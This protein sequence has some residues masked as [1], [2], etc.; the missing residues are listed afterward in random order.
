MKRIAMLLLLTAGIT[1]GAF[2]QTTGTLTLQGTVPGILSITVTPAGA[3]SNLDLTTDV[4]NLTVATV[5][6]RS[7]QKAGYT[8]TVQSAN[9]AASGGNTAYFESTDAA[10]SDTLNYTLTYGGT[11]VSFTSGLATVTDTTSKTL[12]TGTTKNLNISY[13]G[14]TNFLTASTYQDTLTFTITAK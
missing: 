8:V 10:V 11:P 9:A 3:A 2:A 13:T 7:N 5:T 1:A 4:S 12:G 14:S 6:E